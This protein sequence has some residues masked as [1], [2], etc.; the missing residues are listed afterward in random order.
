[1]LSKGFSLL[2]LLAAPSLAKEPMVTSVDSIGY[3]VHDMERVVSFFTD[4]LTFEKVS[5]TEVTGTDIEALFGVFGARIRF[6]ELELGNERVF[7][8]QFIAPRGRAIPADW[9]SHDG[10]FQHIAIVVSDMDAAYKKLRKHNVEH[11]S[12][13][14]QRLPDWNPNAGGIK[15]FYFKDP[16]GHVLELL[17]FP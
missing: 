16:E 17:E 8:K 4:V 5:D 3:T 1:M 2:L 12:T 14:P 15:A 7:F 13:G 11:V 9:R 6:V 10:W